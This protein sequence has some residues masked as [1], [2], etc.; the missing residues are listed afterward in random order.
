MPKA[1]PFHGIEMLASTKK[2]IAIEQMRNSPLE[3]YSLIFFFLLSIFF[4]A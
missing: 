4:V 2:H 1:I 3:K